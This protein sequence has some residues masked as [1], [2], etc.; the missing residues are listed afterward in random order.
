MLNLPVRALFPRFQPRRRLSFTAFGRY[1]TPSTQ[2]I[3]YRTN[4]RLSTLFSCAAGQ[5][6]A[7]FRFASSPSSSSR[8]IRQIR[9]SEI[10]TP[11]FRCKPMDSLLSSRICTNGKCPYTTKKSPIARGLLCFDQSLRAAF[12]ISQRFANAFMSVIARSARTLRL[13]STLASFRPLM[14]RL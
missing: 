9:L 12:A 8:H 6:P 14:R 4:P 13:M 10:R 7:S 3:L 11:I 1:L 2:G 5:S